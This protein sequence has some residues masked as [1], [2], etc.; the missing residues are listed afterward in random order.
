MEESQQNSNKLQ[1][2]DTLLVLNY[3]RRKPIHSRT[4]LG[5]LVRALVIAVLIQRL[6]WRTLRLQRSAEHLQTLVMQLRA[7]EQ[8]EKK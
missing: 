4:R 7:K 2:L 8:A 5:L 6:H 3:L 1:T